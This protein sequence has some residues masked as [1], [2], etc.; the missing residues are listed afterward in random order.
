LLGAVLFLSAF[1]PCSTKAAGVTIVTHGYEFGSSYPTWVTAM[2]DSIPN[3]P[4][5][6]GTNFTTYKLTLSNN[7]GGYLFSSTRTNGS[8]PFA[9]VS[10]LGLEAGL[11]NIFCGFTSE[12]Y[13]A[14]R[15]PSR[16]KCRSLPDEV[17]N[18]VRHITSDLREQV[19]FLGSVTAKPWSPSP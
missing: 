14:F 2:A 7:G 6:P 5:F 3:Y 12:D 1:L 17:G 11:E 4:T 18:W 9:T 13:E 8:S 15:P 16:M 19:V 10:V